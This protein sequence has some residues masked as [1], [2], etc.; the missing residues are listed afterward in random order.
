MDEMIVNLN[1]MGLVLTS[2]PNGA[3]GNNLLH[4]AP[5]G[6]E[7]KINRPL[8]QIPLS[9]SSAATSTTPLPPM[10]V[11]LSI[12]EIQASLLESEYS[13][14]LGVTQKNMSEPSIEPLDLG[15]RLLARR[16]KEVSQERAEAA[17]EVERES[18]R[19]RRSARSLSNPL[20]PTAEAQQEAEEDSQN[21]FA[22]PKAPSSSSPS[23]T[24]PTSS[25]Q[26]GFHLGIDEAI[27]FLSDSCS[28]RV[29]ISV[30]RARLR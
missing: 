17:A 15:S 19:L 16:L 22:E 14:L 7:V 27:A 11:V 1:D 12:P 28:M 6:F 5:E 10:Q 26:F 18:E 2:E 13:A 29:S 21:P 24:P 9:S 23:P 25:R 4:Q 20:P 3:R 8:V 30:S